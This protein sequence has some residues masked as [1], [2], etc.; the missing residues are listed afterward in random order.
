M[1][2]QQQQQLHQH[3]LFCCCI[4]RLQNVQQLQHTQRRSAESCTLGIQGIGLQNPLKGFQVGLRMFALRLG[5]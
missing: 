2:N 4:H 3:Q 5:E 1:A